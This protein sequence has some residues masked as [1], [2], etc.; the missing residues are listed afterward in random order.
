MKV[1][2]TGAN[3]FL[4]QAVVDA[5]LDAGH[6]VRA[7]FRRPP[8]QARTDVDV[9]VVDLEQDPDLDRELEGVE[10]IIHL[11]GLVSR[12]PE[13]AT[14]MYRLHLACTRKL[15]EA[16]ERRGVARWVLASSSGTVAVSS[17]KRV[18]DE[19]HEPDLE[20]VGRWP[21]YMSKLH[22][23]QE[24]LRWHERGA[25]EPVILNPSLLLGPGDARLS[26]TA[27]VLDVLTGRYPAAVDGTVA[28]VDVR[29][30]APIFAKAL[31]RGR[32]GEKYLLNGANM[33][34]R[35]FAERVALTGGVAG[36]RMVVKGAWAYRGAKLFQGIRTAAGLDPDAGLDPVAVDMARH[37][38][39]CD[40]RRAMSELGFSP[41]DPARTIAD[42]VADLESRN[43]FRR[44]A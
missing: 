25:V 42:T 23:E 11:A 13:D 43:L 8:A 10:A 5:A 15:L 18:M 28:F 38:W 6:Q 22:Q 12:R 14:R 3:G 17:Q 30:C 2:V 27:D 4:G 32:P 41:R 37:H 39:A 1:V 24:V 7:W 40:S 21:Y 44:S 9:R 16:S 26:S 19:D 20:V 35:R 33:S 29:D 31:K 34:V 36:P